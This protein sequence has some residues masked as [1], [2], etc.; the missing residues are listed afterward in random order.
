MAA[1]GKNSYALSLATA[2]G[3]IAG[4]RPMVAP[5]V[6]ACAAKKRWI[7]IGN[8]PFAT[9]F[10]GRASRRVNELA[11][12]ELIA[13]KLPFTSSR[14]NAGP[15]ATRIASGALCGA[16]VC[17]ISKRP[18]WNG[19]LLGGIAAVAGALASHHIR[20]NLARDM[21][22]FSVGLAED[23]VAITGGALIMALIA[24]SE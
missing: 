9:M 15:L 5:A 18:A 17:S 12:G 16:A 1:K 13:D 24:A 2:M 10:V 19:A 8:S 23:A 21:P 14:L 22:D 6:L 11:V 4:L 3:A 7:R 20:K